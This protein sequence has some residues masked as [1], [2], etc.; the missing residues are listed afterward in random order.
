[1]N[2]DSTLALENDIE[3]FN[4]TRLSHILEDTDT[5]I[6][7]D[8]DIFALKDLWFSIQTDKHNREDF[9]IDLHESVRGIKELVKSYKISMKFNRTERDKLANL[10]TRNKIQTL[11]GGFKQ[12]LA[13]MGDSFKMEL[14]ECQ[15]DINL[16]KQNMH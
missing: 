1:M 4:Q 11:I 16:R 3:I 7:P 8:D 6:N 13:N 5:S 12:S 2:T 14:A 15:A 10:A 9:E